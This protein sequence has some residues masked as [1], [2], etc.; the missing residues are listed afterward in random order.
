MFAPDSAALTYAVVTD[1]LLTAARAVQTVT[2]SAEAATIETLPQRIGAVGHAAAEVALSDFCARWDAGLSH[3]VGDSETM[4]R[5][6]AECAAAYVVNEETSEGGF[7]ALLTY[8]PRPPWG[9][10]PSVGPIG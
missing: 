3:L 10:L 8:A 2:D 9:D 6:L 1:E 5:R 7:Q 4:A